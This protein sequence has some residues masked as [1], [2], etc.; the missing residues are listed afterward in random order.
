MFNICV[1]YSNAVYS[2]A[3]RFFHDGKVEVEPTFQSPPSGSLS[4]DKTKA[5]S[6]TRGKFA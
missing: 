1:T 2:L 4:A 5:A 3:S 6:A